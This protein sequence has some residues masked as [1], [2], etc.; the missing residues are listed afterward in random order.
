[1]SKT[2]EENWQERL[3]QA[4]Y[5]TG[6]TVL[7]EE[8]LYRETAEVAPLEELE[9]F[10]DK[11]NGKYQETPKAVMRQVLNKRKK[12]I[13]DQQEKK[14]RTS[15]FWQSFLMKISSEIIIG[16]VVGIVLGYFAFSC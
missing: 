9:L 4:C 1:M 8:Q 10:L 3:L 12:E 5:K 16:V 13:S 15:K 2:I 6:D 14:V 11:P 7:E